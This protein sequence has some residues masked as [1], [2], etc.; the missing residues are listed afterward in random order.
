[1]GEARRDPFQSARDNSL[2]EDGGVADFSDAD[3][4][5]MEAREDFWSMFGEFL[6][7]ATMSCLENKLYVL[8]ES[9]SLPSKFIDVGRETKNQFG[10][11][12]FLNY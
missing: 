6:L 11:R 2:Q 12:W 1:M 7:I 9:I 10:H 3:C 4:G 8:K 5:A